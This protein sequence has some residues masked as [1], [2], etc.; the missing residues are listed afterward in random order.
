MPKDMSMGTFN[1]NDI[2]GEIHGFVTAPAPFPD[3]DP[4]PLLLK[5]NVRSIPGLHADAEQ[6]LHVYALHPEMA[7]KLSIALSEV[8]DQSTR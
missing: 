1:L 8:V 6:S 3:M 4:Q 5:L 2:R 7:R